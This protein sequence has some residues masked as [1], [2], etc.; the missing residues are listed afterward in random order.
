MS[1]AYSDIAF[2]PTVRA[3]QTRLG[4]RS[5]YEPLDHTED[6]RDALGDAEAA[7]IE[8]RDGFY[9]A[10]VSETG[11]PYVQF[12]GG[13]AG[14]LKVLDA[15]TIG[16]ADFR[17]NVQYI[18]I[19]NLNGNERVSIILMDYANQRRLKILGRVRLVDERDDPAL[20]ARLELPHYRARVERAVLITV[21]AYDWNCP[22]HITPRFTEQEIAL[23]VAP[24]HAEITTLKKA[25][26]ESVGAHPA[27]AVLGNG[28][29]PLQIS[30][31]RQLTS[32]VRAFELR[33]PDGSEL[34]L[35]QAGAHIDVPVPLANG[36][37]STRRYSI[38]S[39]PQQRSVYEI[40]VLREDAG[41]GGSTAVHAAFQLGMA[42]HCALP[43]NDFALH[44]DA[45]PTVLIA[46]GI[47]IT[48]IQAMAHHLRSVGR[49]FELHYAARSAA[50][51]AYLP[52]LA[53][54]FGTELRLYA[55]DQGHRL[56]VASVLAR[57][58]ADA[59]FYVCGPAALID[60]VRAAAR[61][62]GIP[63]DRVRFERFLAAPV[64][65][66]NKP[67]DVLLQRS[68]KR[69]RVAPDQTIL[70][71]VEAAG[72]AAPA[73]CRNGSCGTCRVK[74]LGG[75]PLHRDVALSDDERTRA[76]LMC[77]CV[78]RAE[79]AGLTLDL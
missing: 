79:S 9:Q 18:S 26:A 34:P 11:W 12:R 33:A 47:G 27:P 42:L 73:G 48:P 4:S 15:K 36:V 49:R 59:V 17:G 72:I 69:V 50:Q 68:G 58:A 71:A 32:Q 56:D 24:L 66:T 43:G 54:E 75:K 67:V 25:L 60:A 30:A 29:L 74:V 65:A 37:T 13:P 6:R 38:T 78:S 22:Q 51:A 61:L 64:T 16:Y 1:R 63:E 8:A 19:G 21:E 14:F 53:Q 77:I 52:T 45:R 46:G 10:T 5:G 20:V 31:V 7:F 3:V 40:A 41:R 55:A 62:A 76:G 44:A 70:E 23:A 39:H 57:A 2:T 35:V 28:A